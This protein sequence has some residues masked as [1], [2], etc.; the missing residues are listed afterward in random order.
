MHNCHRLR[1]T[2]PLSQAFF[3]QINQ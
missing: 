3:N 1:G 2:G